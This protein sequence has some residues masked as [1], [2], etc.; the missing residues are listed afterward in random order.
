MQPLLT[1]LRVVEGS[2]FIAAPLCGMTLSQLG[3]DV[4]RFDQ[5][6]GGIDY[7]RWPVT[8]DNQS[9]YWA[10]L[11][12][13]KRSF[14]VDLRSER[15]QELVAE[16]ICAGDRDGGIFATNLPARRRLSYDSLSQ[17]RG[18]VIQLE[19]VGDRHG[20]VAVDYTVNCKVGLPLVTGYPDDERPVN[21]VLPAWDNIAAYQAALSIIAAERHRLL[22]GEGQR[23]KM[24]LADVALATMG[25]LG[26]IGEVMIND[27]DRER[28]GTH[29]YGALGRDFVTA[30]GVRLMVLAVS[31]RQWKGLVTVTES[32]E[33]MAAL[34]KASKADFSKEG[35][36]FLARNHI[37]E[38]F[39]AW[40]SQH[41]FADVATAFDANGVCWGKYQTVRELVESDVDVS[42][43]NPMFSKVT[44]PDIGE[45]LVSGQ[46]MSFS[47]V[48][49]APV[50]PAPRLGE[51][52]DE[53][54]AET[55]GLSSV[56]IG[57]LHDE[58][59][60]AGVAE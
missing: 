37:C 9:I 39:H 43:D 51:H 44:Q 60:V 3:A 1:G 5:I 48:N 12:K 4:I 59:V 54:L 40:I 31:A 18:D 57:R 50:R 14:A 2:A 26:F 58:G 24:A 49:R 10:E 29:L 20:R 45:Y 32:S 6:G 36:R 42:T 23:I 38:L 53:I 34:E 28:L 52:T 15:G 41:H 30:D 27:A 17:R 55:L 7:R 22:T 19:I 56:D 16:L 25:H 35:D 33:S 11:N 21:H 8:A 46:P 13:G 47:A